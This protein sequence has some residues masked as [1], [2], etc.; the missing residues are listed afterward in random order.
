VE[1]RPGVKVALPER[2]GAPQ[3]RMDRILMTC[4]QKS[5]RPVV[6][7]R[8]AKARRLPHGGTLGLSVIHIST[9]H[10]PKPVLTRVNQ[11]HPEPLLHLLKVSTMSTIRLRKV[12][13][14]STSA[15][16][17]PSP[18]EA[19]G[20]LATEKAPATAT[21]A[22]SS[23]CGSEAPPASRSGGVDPSFPPGWANAR[24]RHPEAPDGSLC[25]SKSPP[26]GSQCPLPL[27]ERSEG[28][29]VLPQGASVARGGLSTKPQ[30]GR[31]RQP[32]PRR[33]RARALA[34]SQSNRFVG[35]SESPAPSLIPFPNP[36]SCDPLRGVVGGTSSHS[37]PVSYVARRARNLLDLIDGISP[38]LASEIAWRRARSDCYEL[39]ERMAWL[40]QNAAYDDPRKVVNGAAMISDL[41]I[42]SS[43]SLCS[44]SISAEEGKC[45]IKLR[46]VACTLPPPCGSSSF[47]MPKSANFP[48]R[49]RDSASNPRGNERAFETE[50]RGQMCFPNWSLG[51]RENS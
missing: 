24:G 35:N 3:R 22:G 27:W 21:S 18:S 50:F 34:P 23:R 32:E 46:L 1:E 29:E 15:R 40:I 51:P 33:E 9:R 49:R 36:S 11:G 7:L 5:R 26:E 12:S 16:G 44:T 10:P 20:I 31:L 2:L 13:T 38:S 19:D 14:M 28:Q 37:I 4:H 25:G 42:L 8:R 30:G 17:N 43:S 47:E 39:S 6:G 41:S 48:I 45:H